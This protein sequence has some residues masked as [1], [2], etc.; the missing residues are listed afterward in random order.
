MD[1]ET[2]HKEKVKQF[3]EKQYPKDL[4]DSKKEGELN[5]YYK[6]LLIGA[7]AGSLL[8]YYVVLW[9]SCSHFQICNPALSFYALALW[10]V[11]LIVGKIGFATVKKDYS[12]KGYVVLLI[13]LIP[14]VLYFIIFHF[15]PLK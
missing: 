8:S 14:Y 15:F 1:E 11:A 12:P 3:F 9:F 7:A 5:G 4:S 10:A 13:F 2:T 6:G